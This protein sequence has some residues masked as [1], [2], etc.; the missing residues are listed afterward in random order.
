MRQFV[1][2]HRILAAFYP[3]TVVGSIGL[4]SLHLGKLSQLGIYLK[5]STKKKQY[6]NFKP[7]EFPLN[8]DEW[9]LQPYVKVV[10][11]LFLNH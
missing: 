11:K 6:K 2:I 10:W 5:Q 4:F 1:I 3:K 8:A 7:I 9:M